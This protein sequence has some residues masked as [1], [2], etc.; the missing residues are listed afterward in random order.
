MAHIMKWRFDTMDEK[1]YEKIDGWQALERLKNDELV[2]REIDGYILQ[3]KLI[4][5]LLYE[6]EPN[7]DDFD[8]CDI[9]LNEFI[10]SNWY[11]PKPFDIRDASL[12]RPNEWVGA[13]QDLQTR[14]LYKVGFDKEIMQLVEA[15]YDNPF[16]C[17]LS[18]LHVHLLDES[19][20]FG[21][22]FPIEQVDSPS[23]EK[24]KAFDT[25]VPF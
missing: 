23:E 21:D 11:I 17:L 1:R 20:N 4:A 7:E 14:K 10:E 2:T 6:R 24:A 15:E 3:T 18:R 19:V 16:D 25:D 22:I 5:G 12:E 13:Y 8:I 9:V